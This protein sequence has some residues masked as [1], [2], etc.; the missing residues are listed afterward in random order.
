MLRECVC[1]CM[2]LSVCVGICRRVSVHA[3]VC[4]RARHL[5]LGAH[6]ELVLMQ[7]VG[8]LRHVQLQ[9][10]VQLVDLREVDL[11]KVLRRPLQVGA[12]HALR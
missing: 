1:A 12:V 8:E 7:Q 9:E 5:R 3:R 2:S 4:V 6:G 10:L 11:H